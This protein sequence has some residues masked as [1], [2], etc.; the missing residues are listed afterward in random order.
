MENLGQMDGSDYQNNML[1]REVITD[2]LPTM[3]PSITLDQIKARLK[4]TRTRLEI[5]KQ[6]VAA[7][8]RVL[9]VEEG[10]VM[11]SDASVNKSEILREFLRSHRQTGVT[12][13]QIKEHFES[14]GVR[15]GSNFTY[16]LINK[17]RD[18]IDRKNGRIFWKGE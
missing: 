12:Y 6:E 1:T 4:D 10:K 7:W 5:I 8:E 9:A 17:W 11:P 15:M 13:A 14:M 3:T 18:L 16:N 2:I